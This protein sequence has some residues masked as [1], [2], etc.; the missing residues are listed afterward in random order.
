MKRMSI[1]AGLLLLMISNIYAQNPPQ[2]PNADSMQEFWQ[3][4]QTAVTKGDKQTVA[5]LSVYPIS[6][7][8]GIKNIRNKAQL[9]KSYRTIFF[10]EGNAA[11]CFPKAKPTVDPQRP[12][13]FTIGCRMTGG[14]DEEPLVYT[15]RFGRNGWRFTSF[16]NINE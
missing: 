16:D 8:Y 3:K 1:Y 7:P 9:L 14:S 5:A 11:E 10:S 2:K 15:F 12:N 4:F 6:M 13:E